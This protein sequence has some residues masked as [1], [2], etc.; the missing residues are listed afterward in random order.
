MGNFR[1]RENINL[2]PHG[3]S[4]YF[5]EVPVQIIGGSK[6]RILFVTADGGLSSDEQDAKPFTVALEAIAYAVNV[7]G[8]C[9]YHQDFHPNPKQPENCIE[10]SVDYESG[11]VTARHNTKALY[12]PFPVFKALREVPFKTKEA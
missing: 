6:T 10:L 9:C 3:Y 7:A 8:L 11:T 4:S 2:P 12:I 5:I 1:L